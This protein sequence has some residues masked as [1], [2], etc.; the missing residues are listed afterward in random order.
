[1]QVTYTHT[2]AH[3]PMRSMK[4]LKDWLLRLVRVTFMA[5]AKSARSARCCQRSFI[6]SSFCDVKLKGNIG[7]N[8]KVRLWFRGDVGVKDNG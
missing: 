2:N 3:L 5:K 8:S 6:D 4:L 7:A 1:M